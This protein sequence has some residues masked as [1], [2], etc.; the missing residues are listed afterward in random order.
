MLQVGRKSFAWRVAADGSVSQVAVRTG[1]ARR[2]GRVEVLEGLAAGDRVVV[3]GI[4]QLR[5]GA[6]VVEAAAA[7]AAQG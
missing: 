6:K 7:A 1:A 2:R 3:E 4:G 5:P